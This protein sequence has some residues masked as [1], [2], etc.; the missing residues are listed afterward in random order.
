VLLQG[1]KETGGTLASLIVLENML[2]WQIQMASNTTTDIVV[3][4]QLLDDPCPFPHSF[5]EL[6]KSQ[7]KPDQLS[8]E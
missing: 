7:K 4:S 5:V 8:F 2:E 6:S 3:P 1:E